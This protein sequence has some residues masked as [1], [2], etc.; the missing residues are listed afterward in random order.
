MTQTPL[1]RRRLLQLMGLG[2]A[3]AL[4]GCAAPGSTGGG[5]AGAVAGG[6]AIP[7][8][9]AQ[10]E[11]SFAHWRAEDKAVFDE[12]IA[13]FTEE[14]KDVTVTQDIS[15]SNDYQ[16]SA[17]QRIRNGDVGDVFVSFRGAQ[18]SDM[19]KAGLYQP[20][21]GQSVVDDYES[22][23]IEPGRQTGIQYGLPYQL[24]FNMPVA[25]VDALERAG[26]SEAPRDWDGWLAMCQALEGEGLVPLA[27]PGGDVGNAGHLLNAMVMNNA[28]SDDMFAKIESGEYACTDDWFVSTLEQYAQ[29]R[30]FMQPNATGTA[31]EPAQQLFAQGKAAM[32]ATG[33][34]HMAAVRALGATFPMDLI[35]PITVGADQ[36]KYEGISNATF[37]LGINARSDVQPAALAFVDFLSQPDSA[38]TYANG[39]AQ[40]VTVKDANYTNRDLKATERWL[41]KRTLLAPRF[42]FL[43]LDLRNAVENAAIQVI[44]GARPQQA[45]QAAQK[46]VDQR[47]SAAS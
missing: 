16:T 2:G 45:A 44:G 30:P 43:D 24:V 6:A 47:R 25:N 33:S 32:L 15:P 21:G 13:A 29:L 41:T 9:P 36:A 14:H 20:L 22:T 26:I 27:W 18:F 35:A 8:G 46:I 37:I 39:T 5:P 7:T 10:G 3:G 17:L 28:P 1:T 11:V 4:A 19:V 38:S 31:V 42:Q 23:F 12:L 40:H 34:F